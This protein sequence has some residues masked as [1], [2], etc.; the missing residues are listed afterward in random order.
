ME[1]Q[2]MLE[3]ILA[4]QE[5]NKAWQARSDANAKTKCKEQMLAMQEQNR[6]D[7]EESKAWQKANTEVT[8]TNKEEMM[9]KLATKE[10]MEADRRRR[11]AEMDAVLSKMDERIAAIQGKTDMKLEELTEP[12]EEM[13]QSAEEHHEV[14]DEGAVEAPVRIRKRRHK[15][16]KET[17]GRRLEP[18]GLNRGDRGS[19]KKLAAACRKAS[20][21]ATVAW[22]KRNVFRKSWTCEFYGLRKEVTAPRKEVTAPRKEVTR[23][24]R[25]R[26]KVAQRSPT[27]GAFEH[28]CRRGS[29]YGMGRKDPTVIDIGGWSSRQLSPLERRGSIYKIRK[30]TLN[31]ESLR[32]APGMFIGLQQMRIW[33]LWRGRPPPKRKCCPALGGL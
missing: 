19:R 24:E 29:Q 15:G 13:M 2:Q 33:T 27:G 9:A 32:R 26:R 28:R 1:M 22:I 30:T 10:D 17:A 21:R 16:R 12:R 5:E 23:C 14:P 7:R 3:R 11:K 25:H 4:G 6:A 31:T 20:H 18:K 8:L